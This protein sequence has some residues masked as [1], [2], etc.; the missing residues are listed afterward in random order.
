MTLDCDEWRL[1]VRPY[2]NASYNL[3]DDEAGPGGVGGKIDEESESE[4]HQ[5]YAEPDWFAVA[6]GFLDEDSCCCGG[7]GEGDG[8]GEEV[9][10]GIRLDSRTGLFGSRGGGSTFQ[11]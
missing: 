5:G 9:D 8:E 7:E 3:E 10:A 2:A 4:R 1:K 6:A 11:R